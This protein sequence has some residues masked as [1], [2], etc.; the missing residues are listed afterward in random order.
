MPSSVSEQLRASLLATRDEADRVLVDAER[1]AAELA[2]LA[3]KTDRAFIHARLERLR[4]MRAQIEAQGA[5]I[6]SSYVALAE[7]MAA[8]SMRL[9][10]IARDADFS[11]PPWPSGIRRTVEIRFAETREV[12]FRIET[13]DAQGDD[14]PSRPL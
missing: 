7:A 13:G 1:Q 10:A 2:D 8:S 5:Q 3:G 12:T 6:E 14:A 4:S 9:A 11:I